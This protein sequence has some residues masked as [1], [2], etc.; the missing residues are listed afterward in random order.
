MNLICPTT[1]PVANQRICPFRIMCIDSY[2]AIVFSAPPTDPNGTSRR[3]VLELEAGHKLA[4][5]RLGVYRRS[6]NGAEPGDDLLAGRAGS[7][8][9]ARQLAN[10]RRLRVDARRVDC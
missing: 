9:A 1:S 6:C 7:V 3:C 2:P 8:A 5:P 10:R 4:R